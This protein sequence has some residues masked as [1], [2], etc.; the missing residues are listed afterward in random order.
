MGLTSEQSERFSRQ[1]RI[2]GVEV[3]EKIIGE[4]VAVLSSAHSVV[5]DEILKNLAL[6]GCLHLYANIRPRTGASIWQ[7]ATYCASSSGLPEEAFF[8]CIDTPSPVTSNFFSIRT[9]SHS[10]SHN[11]E[12]LFPPAT[13]EYPLEYSVVLAGVAV[14]EYIK[15]LQGLGVAER[16]K[17][18]L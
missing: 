6:L 14:Q 15:L 16:Y 1:I 12:N 13:T 4:R 17:V 9:D 5:A 11:A 10:F 2:F 8:F 18:E 7:G 3:Q